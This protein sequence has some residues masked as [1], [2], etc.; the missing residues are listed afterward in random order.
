MTNQ[1]K[2]ILIIGL[3]LVATIITIILYHPASPGSKEAGTSSMEQHIASLQV[4]EIDSGWAYKVMVDTT[5]LIYQKQIPGI[6]GAPKFTSKKDAQKC[7]EL[8]MQ[9][10]KKQRIPSISRAEL[11]SLGINY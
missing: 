7:G 10:L 4:V 5:V 9:K 8:V 3:I 11:D 2:G 6:S 1:K